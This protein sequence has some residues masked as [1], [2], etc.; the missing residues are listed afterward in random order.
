MSTAVRASAFT[1]PDRPKDLQIRYVTVGGAYLDV[2]GSGEHVQD[3]R[4]VCRGCK[5]TSRAPE[6][7]WLFRIREEASAHASACRAIPLT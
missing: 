3:N 6:T 5:E 2:T 4:W 7:D 1:E